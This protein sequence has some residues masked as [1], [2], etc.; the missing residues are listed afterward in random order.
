[1]T[2]IVFEVTEDEVDGGYCASAIRY[3]IH[4]QSDS[5]E[6]ICSNVKEAVDCYFDET[7]PR[8]DT[9]RL[10]FV[11]DETFTTCIKAEYF[12]LPGNL[13]SG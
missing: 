13:C 11:C 1:M 5:V 10:Q 3:S 8:P 6:E 7:M 9:I 12:L 2:E 4:T